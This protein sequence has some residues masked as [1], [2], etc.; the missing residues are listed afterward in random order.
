LAR[1]GY[2]ALVLRS[3]GHSADSQF[4]LVRDGAEASLCGLPLTTLGP[5]EAELGRVCADCIDWLPKR[6]A[7][8]GAYKVPKEPR[9]G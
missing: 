9:K 8:T 6:M 5:G 3:A 2:R 7:A 1:H 4:H